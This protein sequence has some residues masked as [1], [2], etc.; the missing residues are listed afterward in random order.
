[1]SEEHIPMYPTAS[2]LKFL[3]ALNEWICGFVSASPRAGAARGGG[4]GGGC[5]SRTPTCAP[6]QAAWRAAGGRVRQAEPP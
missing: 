4:P 6:T 3:G 1:M 2:H 5:W